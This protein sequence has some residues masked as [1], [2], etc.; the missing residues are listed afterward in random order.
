MINLISTTLCMKNKVFILLFPFA[1]QT[2]FPQHHKRSRNIISFVVF[3]CTHRTQTI[4]SFEGFSLLNQFFNYRFCLFVYLVFMYSS[5]V[6]HKIFTLAHR[7]NLNIPT[8]IF[9]ILIIHFLTWIDKTRV[10]SR[11]SQS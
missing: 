6:P 9:K 5:F 11:K 10:S 7:L 4:P 8:C 3:L 2:I 1:Q